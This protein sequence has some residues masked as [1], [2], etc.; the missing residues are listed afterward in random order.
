V[1]EEIREK[2]EEFRLFSKHIQDVI[3]I[4]KFK[5]KYSNANNS[6]NQC[7]PLSSERGGPQA[8]LILTHRLATIRSAGE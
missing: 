4:T 6:I 7:P 8:E 2:I 5:E 3:S 1:R